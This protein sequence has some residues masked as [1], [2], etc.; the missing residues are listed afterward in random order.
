MC[1]MDGHRGMHNLRCMRL[2]HD[3]RLD[4][5][6]NMMMDV[7]PFES[8]CRRRSLS[9]L[10]CRRGI[11]VLGHV[12][13]EGGAK[14]ALITMF[15]RLVLDRNNIM[16]MLLFTVKLSDAILEKSVMSM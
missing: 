4:V 5:L 9:G 6:V 2:F 3:D 1:L 10:M 14:L 7:L 11:L 12:G 15:E 13:F 16:S 8:G